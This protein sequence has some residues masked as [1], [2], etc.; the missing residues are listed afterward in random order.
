MYVCM[1]V[2]MV[3]WSLGLF[4]VS[5]T[6]WMDLACCHIKWTKVK[7]VA[8]WFCLHVSGGGVYLWVHSRQ[9]ILRS[10]Q[11][12]VCS[13]YLRGV[14]GREGCPY[15][16]VNVGRDA[17]VCNDFLKGHCP[18]GT[19]VLHAACD[20]ATSVLCSQATPVLSLPCSAPSC[21]R[22]IAL[23]SACLES[24]HEEASVH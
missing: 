16:H 4:E 23:S 7:Y 5:V 9:S 21:M 18:H 19:E 22:T 13:F 8:S 6:R 17:E 24:A 12:P 1:Y 3:V 2:P 11:M 15:L 20:V 14:C 10:L